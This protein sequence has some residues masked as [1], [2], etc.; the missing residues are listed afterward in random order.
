LAFVLADLADGGTQRVATSMANALAADG[1]HVGV[2]TFSGP[3]R[4][5][6]E[7]DSTVRRVVLGGAGETNS[8]VAAVR[9]NL[10]R[11]ISLR[12]SLRD[13]KVVAAVGFILP[14]NILLLLASIN[15]GMRV[16]LSERNDPARQVFR[17]YWKAL[18]WIFYRFSD[19]VT[20]NSQA[21]VETMKAYVPAQKLIFLPNPLPKLP[22]KD[23]SPGPTILAIGRLHPQKAHDVLIDAFAGIA[24]KFRDW[25]V[26]ILGEGHFRSVLESRIVEMSLEERVCLPGWADDPYPHYQSAGMFVLVSRYEGTSN[27]LLEA[28]GSGLAI[29]VSDSCPGSTDLIKD[30]VSGLV[31][32]V[33]DADALAGALSR[34]IEDESLRTRLGRAA[35]ECFYALEKNEDVLGVWRAILLGNHV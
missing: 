27:A 24:G 3:E 10:G 17:G 12:R 4:D 2:M 16:L 26:R 20:A 9:A 5:C 30:G 6:Y 7:L 34:L 19:T 15:L 23:P 18:R 29:I 35:Q 21:A 13:E 31:V 14:I 8:L 32:P 25:N 33:D 28:M 11:I 1:Q 22:K